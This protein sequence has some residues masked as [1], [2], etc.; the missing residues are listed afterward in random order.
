VDW[1]HSQSAGL[2]SLLIIVTLS[3]FF[4]GT[5]EIIFWVWMMSWWVLC[6]NSPCPMIAHRWAQ[7]WPVPSTNATQLIG[8]RK[9]FIHVVDQIPNILPLT[10]QRILPFKRNFS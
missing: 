8:Q 9:Y 7:Q 5:M 3:G 10:P 6:L 1:N 2:Y 4:V